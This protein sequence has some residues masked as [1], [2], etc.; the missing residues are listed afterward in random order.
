MAETSGTS[1]PTNNI[2]M[3]AGSSRTDRDY[4][5]D[6]RFRERDDRHRR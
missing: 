1:C 2:S 5:K 6:E 4:S 3:K